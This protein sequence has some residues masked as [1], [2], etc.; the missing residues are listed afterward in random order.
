MKTTPPYS[1]L[2]DRLR[3]IIKP[4]RYEESRLVAW[5][6]V[7]DIPM[8]VVALVFL[9]VYAAPIIHPEM[10]PSTV[11]AC[12]LTA[13]IVW[14]IFAADYV[15]RLVIAKHRWPFVRYHIFDLAIVILP[16]FQPLRLLR[17]VFLLRVINRHAG[18]SL[19]GQIFSYVVGAAGI[20]TFVGA[21]AELE[22]ERESS[23]AVITTFPDALWWGFVTITTVGYGDYTPVTSQ[24]RIVATGMM[25]FGVALLGTVTASLAA[26]LVE[27][28]SHE[29]DPVTPELQAIHTLTKHV[30]QLEQEV[31]ALRNQLSRIQRK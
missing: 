19:R 20:I 22:V 15:F 5:A 8:A 3:R 6:R 1:K 31:T 26:W 4:P 23:E 16:F 10:P 27:H 14:I 30:I 29:E 18:N 12:T 11:W 25:I 24:G 2:T 13:D 21:L 17:L 7:S 28:V 9:A